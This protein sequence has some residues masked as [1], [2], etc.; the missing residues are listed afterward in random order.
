MVGDGVFID[1]NGL[2]YIGNY[3]L[4]WGQ[5]GDAYS[6]Q[7]TAAVGARQVGVPDGGLTIMLLGAA[8]SGLALVRRKLA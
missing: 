3:Q 2:S 7:G 1:Q 8:L 6:L 4:N 5:T